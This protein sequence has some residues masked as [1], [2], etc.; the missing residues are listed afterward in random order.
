MSSGKG[1]KEG[2]VPLTVFEILVLPL[3]HVAG[4]CERKEKKE[5]K[6]K[7]KAADVE[8]G[9]VKHG[10]GTSQSPAKN[11]WCEEDSWLI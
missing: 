8:A 7:R 5:K 10:Q 4:S 6:N 9:T 11:R 3:A 1:K 2:D